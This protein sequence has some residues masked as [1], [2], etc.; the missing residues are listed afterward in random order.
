[1]TWIDPATAPDFPPLLSARRIVPGSR[2]FEAATTGA[3]D[4]SLR[5]GD[6][7]WDDDPTRVALAIVLEPDVS[8]GHAA[9]M[10]P[11]AMVAVGDCVG[12]LA[13][14]Q[15]GVTFRWLRTIAVNGASV[16]NVRVA[17]PTGDAACEPD[18]LVVAIDLRMRPAP[19][20]DEPGSAPDRTTLADEGCENLT[21][22]DLMGSFAR[23]FLTWLNIWQDE[24]FGPVRRNWLERAEVDR[25][26]DTE[27]NFAAIDGMDEGGNLLVRSETGQTVTLA[28]FDAVE[29]KSKDC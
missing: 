27:N 26:S 17:S 12:A 7:L 15:V 10:L 8:L 4:G 5:A 24:G 2:V 9:Q 18:W 25:G 13:P 16:G 20:A 6:V 23:H 1:M 3:A 22:F 29:I 28:L 21:N 19:D 11:L 14:P